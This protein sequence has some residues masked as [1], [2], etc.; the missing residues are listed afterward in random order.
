M[1]KINDKH[2]S[3]EFAFADV[4]KHLPKI[5]LPPCIIRQIQHLFDES[6]HEFMIRVLSICFYFNK[7]HS[8]ENNLS[9]HAKTVHISVAQTLHFWEI[10]ENGQ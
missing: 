3:P 2:I 10:L 9:I 5:Q 6:S 1:P 7:K 8:Y 4:F